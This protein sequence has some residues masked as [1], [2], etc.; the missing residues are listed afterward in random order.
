VDVGLAFDPDEW[1]GIAR[2]VL[3]TG[4]F[5]VLAPI[6]A[7]YADRERMTVR[8]L[9]GL[10]YISL[11]RR[12]PL[13]RLLSTHI[14][15]SGVGLQPI[16]WAETYQVAK[17][18]VAQGGG[19]MIADQVTAFSGGLDGLKVWPLEPDL[20]F[21]ISALH[22]ESAPMSLVC[23]EFVDQLRRQVDRFLAQTSGTFHN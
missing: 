21:E 12:G 19:V 13:G 2:E 20:R 5:F 15:S 10:P 17:S 4:S 18:L 8:D 22:L 9:E 3:G 16:A 23:R 1:P 14:E 7:P 11:D 6:D